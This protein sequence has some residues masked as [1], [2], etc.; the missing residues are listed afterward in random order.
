[1]KVDNEK[2]ILWSEAKKI[3]GDLSKDKTLGY[4]QK[5]ALEQL[6]KFSKIKSKDVDDIKTKLSKIERLKENHITSIINMLPKDADEVK[7]LF[8]HEPINLS[9]EERKKIASITKPFG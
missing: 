2:I 1:M 9:E 6:K 4:E 5:N 3:L 8:A 7:L